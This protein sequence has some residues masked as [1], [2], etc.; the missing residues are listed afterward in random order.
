MKTL[1][2]SFLL[3]VVCLTFSCASES[4]NVPSPEENQK[5]FGPGSTLTKDTVSVDTIP[6][7]EVKG[8][9]TPV[10]EV[11][12]EYT[13]EY[14]YAPDAVVIPTSVHHLVTYG[15]EEGDSVL[16]ISAAVPDS[17]LP[18]KGDILT[19][20]VSDA[21]P[22]GLGCRVVSVTQE[23]DRYKVLTE[24]AAL[25]E[26]FSKLNIDA[27]FHEV[28][29]EYD[30]A[31]S[32]VSGGYEVVNIDVTTKEK[33]KFMQSNLYAAISYTLHIDLENKEY[34]IG[35]GIYGGYKGNAQV[36]VNGS[37]DL[38]WATWPEK[39]KAKRRRA[40]KIGPLAVF[41]ANSGTLRSVIA[42]ELEAGMD[43]NFSFDVQGGVRNGSVYGD[44]KIVGFDVHTL[45]DNFKWEG[46][47][48]FSLI[49]E[50]NCGMSFFAGHT[51]DVITPSI[52]AVADAKLDFDDVDLFKNSSKIGLAAK[53]GIGVH[54]KI[55]DLLGKTFQTKVDIPDYKVDIWS[56]QYDLF[57]SYEGMDD[58][59]TILRNQNRL[60]IRKCFSLQGGLLCNYV[61]MR[62]V[63]MVYD[64]DELYNVY[65]N[66][67]IIDATTNMSTFFEMDINVYD[68]YIRLCP[69][70]EINGR[71]YPTDGEQLYL[72]SPEVKV[73]GITKTGAT[74][75]EGAEKEEDR[76]YLI[77]FDIHLSLKHV[78]FLRSWGLYSGRDADNLRPYDVPDKDG[79]YSVEAWIKGPQKTFSVAWGTFFTRKG[80]DK[81]N[82]TP[83][84]YTTFSVSNSRASVEEESTPA[85]CELH[86][87]WSTLKRIK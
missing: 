16:Y 79:E 62:P 31:A 74:Y 83:L 32:R 41:T 81:V 82:K 43:F 52:E 66:D 38:V 50:V 44:G 14:Q 7:E 76:I 23:G 45:Y 35:A 69:A 77:D 61:Q 15:D 53:A 21:L 75:Y 20:E 86:I 13:V 2:H 30:D 22:D 39:K 51:I 57:P 3:L 48:S 18:E 33:N 73:I 28:N 10:T 84:Y 72:P 6:S 5:E 78:H 40:K 27:T 71:F 64:G 55:Q 63:M 54:D 56:Q 42:G 11:T 12:D 47:G 85:Q 37:T 70:L 36:K 49:A 4:L 25:D 65:Y 9:D 26:I 60:V 68:H 58:E 80:E 34:E 46:K 59:Y 8:I 87:D 19:A 29:D 1:F 24:P 67:D 17:Y